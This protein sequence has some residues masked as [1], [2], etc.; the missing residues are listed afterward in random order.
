MTPDEAVGKTE[1]EPERANFVLEKVAK[2][3]DQLETQFGG[4]PADVV[5]VLDRRRGTV[6]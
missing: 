2:R 6:E 1:F 4:K 3:L 5:V